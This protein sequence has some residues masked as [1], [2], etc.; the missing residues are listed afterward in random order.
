[1]AKEVEPEPE[2]HDL[3]DYSAWEG[4]VSDEVSDGTGEPEPCDEDET[5]LPLTNIT[6]DTYDANLYRKGFS[7]YLTR[8]LRHDKTA[9]FDF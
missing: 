8:L 3:R 7:K 6:A 9:P 5:M 4:H 2:T 1:M